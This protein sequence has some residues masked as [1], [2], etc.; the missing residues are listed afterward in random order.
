MDF[1]ISK[2]DDADKLTLLRNVVSSGKILAKAT[3]TTLDDL[4]FQM[5]DAGVGPRVVGHALLNADATGDVSN[6]DPASIL[7]L[8]EIAKKI[9]DLFR[10][11]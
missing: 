8:I 1:D 4:I 7:A 5:L 11:K 6:L 3:G 9:W 10:K 2:L